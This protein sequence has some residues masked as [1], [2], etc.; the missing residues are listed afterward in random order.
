MRR[1][2]TECSPSSLAVPLERLKG[3]GEKRAKAL[4]G[5]GL[6][7]VFDLLFRFPLRYEDRA[8]FTPIAELAPGAAATVV[9]EVRSCRMKPTRRPGFSLFEASIHDGSSPATALWFNQPFLA[10][11]IRQGQ[12]VVLYGHVDAAP[13]AMRQL[14]NPE[15]EI[16]DD[17]HEAQSSLHMGRIVPV[18]ERI[19]SM[20]VKLQRALV[21]QALETLPSEVDDPVP[22]DVL[23]RHGLPGRRRA[24]A[25]VHFPEAGTSLDLLAARATPAHHRLVFEEFYLFQLSVAFR[26]SR[27]I[28]E[29]KAWRVS[30]DDR[31]RDRARAVLPFALTG[32]QK[33]ALK[34]VVEDLQKPT[35]MNR[36]LQGEVGSGKTIVAVL[37]ALVA[38]DNGLQVALMAPTELLAQQHATR[39]E[40]LLAPTGHRVVSLTG[41]LR[42]SERKAVLR[43]LHAAGPVL[44]IGTHALVQHAVHFERMGLVIIDEQ[45][46]FGVVQ[47]ADLRSKGL[48][49]DVLVMTATP[50]PRTLALTVYGDLD[51]SVLRHVPPGRQ[52]VATTVR[53]DGRRDEAYEF[54]ARQVALGRQAYLVYP[55]IDESE[56]IE[57]RAVTQ[58][59][60]HLATDVFPSLRV[61]M[62]HGRLDRD[63]RQRVMEQFA[64]GEIDVL[65]ST[66][67]VEVGIDVPNATVM[68]VEHAERFGLAQLHQLRGRVGRG[69]HASY[70]LFLYQP[71]L[72]DVARARLRA[73]AETSDGFALAERDLE[74]RGPGD[75]WGTRQSGLPSLRV[76]DWLRDRVWLELAGA[77]AAGV[78]ESRMSDAAWVSATERAWDQRF[79]RIEVS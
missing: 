28:A 19:G 67:V 5:A 54:V 15:F 45:H 46:R 76:G 20:T 35:P 25:D 78:V 23:Q 75:F 36:L 43:S 49:P 63:T 7:T 69:H 14:T 50:I 3:V 56:K 38:L 48:T 26:R 10:Q 42:P 11:V 79:A 57:L 72:G 66:T 24:L 1:V 21:A 58:M 2:A 53:P 34:E 40:A 22:A 73:I 64:R 33:Q 59:V 65:V 18:Y 55:L 9:G 30:V 39:I 13:G 70:C 37:A 41:E 62:L 74:I 27:R 32:D 61:S 31:I 17:G 6:H 8:R 71:P 16:V 52:P 44:V 51:L 60:D 77:E 68:V 4:A 29:R 47:R 12:R